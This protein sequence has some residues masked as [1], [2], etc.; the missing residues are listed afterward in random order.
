MYALK[1][2]IIGWSCQNLSS[3]FLVMP[4]TSR[5]SHVSVRDKKHVR[6]PFFRGAQIFDCGY[7][8]HFLTNFDKIW[9]GWGF[10][11]VAS[12]KNFGELWPT[13]SG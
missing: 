10:C 8:R 2:Y 1:S 4:L 3:L 6:G 13:F 5:R 7:L 12:P 11:G 9:V